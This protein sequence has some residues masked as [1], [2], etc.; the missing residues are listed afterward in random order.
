M[1]TVGVISDTHGILDRKVTKLF[2]GVDHILH[3]G[4]IGTESVLQEL[5][6]I[7]PVTAVSGNCDCGLDREETEVVVL[8]GFKFVLRH[9]F[10]ARSP[11][12]EIRA[13]IRQEKPHVLVFG[14]T[15]AP[16][17]ERWGDVLLFNP[18]YAGRQRFKL[19]RS[20]G[21]LRCDDLG[22][23]ATHIGL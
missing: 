20:I 1:I 11:G 2:A 5:E 10:D 19:P 15:H 3:A 22:I 23:S 21:I 17:N 12:A 18:G 14:H 16:C 8:G 7:A 9:I 13:L 6:R 4:D